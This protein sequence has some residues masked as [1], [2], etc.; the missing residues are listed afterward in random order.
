MQLFKKPN[1]EPKN[2]LA[3]LQAEIFATEKR[4]EGLQGK[5]ARKDG[6]LDVEYQEKLAILKK[7]TDELEN[8]LAIKRSEYTQLCK[9]FE[10][11]LGTLNEREKTL[12][13]RER[14][15]AECE[16]SVFEREHDVENKLQGVQELCNQVGETT[17]KQADKERILTSREET[18]KQKETEILVG[19]EQLA[20]QRNRVQAELLTREEAVALRELNVESAL[21]NIANREKQIVKDLR[22]IQDRKAMH[23][24]L[25]NK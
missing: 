8:N 4:L 25:S 13:E 3:K 15:L 16:Q 17:I 21:E 20:E 22:L 24:R 14:T 18:L 5:Y 1:L 7:D 23:Q 9:P 12:D 6:E 19:F 11:K 2:Y 10:N